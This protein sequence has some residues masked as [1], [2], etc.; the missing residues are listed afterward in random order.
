MCVHACV[1]CTSMLAAQ[2]CAHTQLFGCSHSA[3]Q[4]GDSALWQIGSWD[5]SKTNSHMTSTPGRSLLFCGKPFST[6]LKYFWWM[7]QERGSLRLAK[8]VPFKSPWCFSWLLY[9]PGILRKVPLAYS[10]KCR[11]RTLAGRTIKH[12]VESDLGKRKKLPSGWRTPFALH[13]C[14]TEGTSAI[15]PAFS[16]RR[17]WTQQLWDLQWDLDL[18]HQEW[19]SLAALNQ[20]EGSV[21]QMWSLWTCSFISS[22]PLILLSFQSL[23]HLSP[24]LDALSSESGR[25]SVGKSS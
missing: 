14:P 25:I 20:S 18:P 17:S 1:C 21:S 15:W 24:C 7:F 4:R 2:S 22:H 16:A 3:R 12:L 10:V 6:R 5:P 11:T 9:Q 19:R 8:E 13:S 23:I